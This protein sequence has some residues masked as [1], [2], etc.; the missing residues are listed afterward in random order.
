MSV[1]A[2]RNS[3]GG[4]RFRAAQAGDARACAPLV[5]ASGV[6]EFGFVLGADTELCIAFLTFAFGRRYGRFSWQRHRVAVADDGTVL[7]V[8]AVHDGRRTM[9][10]DLHVVRDLLRFFGP[11]RTIGMLLR[12]LVL[13]S[14]LPAPKRS[15]MLVAHCATH[16]RHRGIGIFSALFEDALRAGTLPARGGRDVVLDVLTTNVRAKS[17]YE[18][19]GFV[20][21]PRVRAPS[22]RLP[23]ALE[24]VRMRLEWRT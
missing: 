5:F 1:V 13:E 3:H 23:R 4:V 11:G 18:R 6:G 9:L 14:E 19:L 12:G 17:L 8:M 7:A 20:V 16:E 10:D 2:I 24:S 22:R 21:M 15:Q